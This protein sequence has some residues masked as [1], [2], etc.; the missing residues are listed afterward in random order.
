MCV[1]DLPVCVIYVLVYVQ[2][3]SDQK[4]ASRPLE[5]ES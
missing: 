3:P 2:C 1:D 5:M 4:R